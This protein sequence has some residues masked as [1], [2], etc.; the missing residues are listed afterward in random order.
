MKKL[1]L[2]TLTALM[3]AQPALAG[4]G[5]LGLHLRELVLLINGRE[6]CE[7]DDW[8]NYN[9]TYKNSH[10]QD[11]IVIERQTYDIN[12]R[13]EK[14]TTNHSWNIYNNLV[15]VHIWWDRIDKE[16]DIMAR[17]SKDGKHYTFLESE[18]HIWE[19]N[20][21]LGYKIGEKALH[22]LRALDQSRVLRGEY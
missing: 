16:W 9:G 5:G 20:Q 19:I 21:A 18:K 22:N 17:E 11:V 4:W 6:N 1:I 3:L 7:V 12:C 14:Y 13:K 8:F 10:N 15:Y 2:T